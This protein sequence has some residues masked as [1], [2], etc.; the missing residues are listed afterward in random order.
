M[1]VVDDTVILGD[2]QGNDRRYA[3]VVIAAG[4]GAF[5]PNRPP[6]DNLAVFE[7]RSVFYH[8]DAIERF[9]GKKVVICGGGDSALD[10]VMAL[11]TKA[12]VTLVHRR[13]Q[14]RATPATLKKIDQLTKDK[15]ITVITPYVLSRIEGEDDGRLRYVIIKTLQGEEKRLPADALLAFFGLKSQLGAISQWQLHID[16]DAICVEPTTMQTSLAAG[17][18]RW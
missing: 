8:V 12:E 5:V 13:A 4:G 17:F 10:W 11:A 7:G 9:Y 16:K 15:T 2:A 14:F 6:L 3:A 1:R 18:C